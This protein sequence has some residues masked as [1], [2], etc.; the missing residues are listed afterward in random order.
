MK[1]WSTHNHRTAVVN[2]N[3]SNRMSKMKVQRDLEFILMCHLIE[4]IL[5]VNRYK[6]Q[7][8]QYSHTRALS[9]TRGQNTTKKSTDCTETTIDHGSNQP[10]MLATPL[11]RRIVVRSTIVNVRPM[12]LAPHVTLFARSLIISMVIV[13]EKAERTLWRYSCAPFSL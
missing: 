6:L 3:K 9:S 1:T 13:G 11:N 5:T 10:P 7:Q 2:V 4:R 12:L 8:S